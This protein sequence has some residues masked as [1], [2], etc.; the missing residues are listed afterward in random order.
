MFQYKSI[1]DN[2]KIFISN[3]DVILYYLYLFL[4]DI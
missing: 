2:V 3:F 1:N 4:I